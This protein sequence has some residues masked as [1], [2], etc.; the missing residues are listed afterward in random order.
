MP[1]MPPHVSTT[2]DD[3]VRH[4][5]TQPATTFDA[6]A[7]ASPTLPK[8][9]ISKTSFSSGVCFYPPS[10]KY[11]RIGNKWYDFT[12][13]LDQH[14][15]G[16]ILLSKSP[17]PVQLQVALLIVWVNRTSNGT[18]VPSRLIFQRQ[19]YPWISTIELPLELLW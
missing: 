11:W 15:G 9:N 3:G 12:D 18:K 1:P 14:P 4:R 8:E 13:F 10:T 2:P 17:V 16:A 7:R 19:D 5:T 6:D